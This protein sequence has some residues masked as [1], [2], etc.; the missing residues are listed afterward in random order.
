FSSHSPPQ[1]PMQFIGVHPLN[2][3]NSSY[4]PQGAMYAEANIKNTITGLS[5]ALASMQ[6]Q[7]IGLQQQQVS[8]EEKQDSISGTL[9][10]VMSLLQE[11][12]R[13]SKNVSQN[14]CISSN[15][16]GGMESLEHN[17]REISAQP[18]G[19]RA[20]GDQVN[21]ERQFERIRTDTDR[22]THAVIQSDVNYSS[23]TSQNHDARWADN[24][25]RTDRP[26]YNYSGNTY[27]YNSTYGYG[28][29]NDN[30]SRHVR[31]R[32]H[33]NP[34]IQ[35]RHLGARD[36]RYQTQGGSNE[37][38]LPPFN[39][40]EEWKVWVSR[41]EAI[42]NR[43]QWSNETKLDNLLPKLQGKAGEFVFTQLPSHTLSHYEDLIKELNSR[44]RVVETKKTFAA[45]FSQRT[46][47]PGETAE[48]FA[49]ELKR[50]YAKAYSFR[51]ENTRQE[52]LVR[53][54]LDG[55][56]DSDA[57]FEIEYNKEPEDID[58]AV[59][60]AVNFIQT[61]HRGSAD[62]SSDRKFKRYARRAKQEED[63][64]ASEESQDESEEL[65]RVCR[66]PAKN[67][68][69]Q[70]KKAERTD[71]KRDSGNLKSDTEKESLKVL[72]EAK[73]MMTSLMN[74]MQ[75]IVKSTN[76]APTQQQEQKPFRGRNIVCYGCSQMGNVIRDCPQRND[77][78]RGNRPQGQTFPNRGTGRKLQGDSGE[79][80]NLN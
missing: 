22:S 9:T 61:K 57:R 31:F 38:K 33:D 54:F 8:M 53:R 45:K 52:D 41:F 26:D 72:T 71:Q 11:L 3:L 10:N 39:G 34:R 19:N 40:K 50:L 63:G 2:M 7:Q 46:Q 16:S 28:L 55:L 18:T 37:I 75:E 78:Y 13:K 4:G 79:D 80:Q 15:E 64:S 77:K 43:R 51:D 29:E 20:A 56:R 67:D 60:H 73:D 14:N 48:E 42:A 65:D 74:Q 30:A 70:K 58:E 66:L 24:Y 25:Q 59:Y 76:T 47:K 12:T 68:T 35:N 5:N 49:A 62:S 21:Y 17:A 6:Q 36:D 27:R 69:S 23:S 32:T 44:F 1:Q